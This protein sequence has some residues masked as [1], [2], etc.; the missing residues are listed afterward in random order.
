[1]MPA[2]TPAVHAP[3]S[4]GPIGFNGRTQPLLAAAGCRLLALETRKQG[5]VLTCRLRFFCRAALSD[6]LPRHVLTI[7]YGFAAFVSRVADYGS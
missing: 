2:L 5:A 3:D 7:G 4:V 6:A 1:M